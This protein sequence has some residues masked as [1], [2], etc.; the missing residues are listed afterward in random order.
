MNM[1]MTAMTDHHQQHST[2]Q[3]QELSA[4]TEDT[5]NTSSLSLSSTQQH[6]TLHH[7][8][9]Q[10]GSAITTPTLHPS[11]SHPLTATSEAMSIDSEEAAA[12]DFLGLPRRIKSNN[13]NN[14]EST[15]SLI[16]SDA[17]LSSTPQNHQLSISDT[18][19]ILSAK[20]APF[21]SPTKVQASSNTSKLTP[22]SFKDFPLWK[23]KTLSHTT[24]HGLLLTRGVTAI[25][26]PHTL[27]VTPSTRKLKT[28]TGLHYKNELFGKQA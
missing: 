7:Q 24:Y 13:T 15:P 12:W 4:A 21:A 27:T 11:P 20:D 26:F 16:S 22:T 10:Q 9:E 8:Q 28:S 6:P 19:T 2:E 17:P 5:N 23:R 1:M 3:Q 25:S 14:I 18:A